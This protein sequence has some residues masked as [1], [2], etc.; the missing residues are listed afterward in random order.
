MNPSTAAVFVEKRGD[1]GQRA[2]LRYIYSGQLPTADALRQVLAG[3]RPD[4]GWQS[5]WA[6]DYSSIDATCY[7]LAQAEQLALGAGEPALMRAL[8]FLAQRQQADGAWE[9]EP[10]LSSM[11]PP[12]AMPGSREARLYLTANSGYWLAR[13]AP[14]EMGSLRESAT[15]AAGYLLLYLGGRDRLPSFLQADW[16]AAGMWQ[17]LGR[18]DLA[19]RLCTFLESRVSEMPA[20]SLAWLILA[21]RGAGLDASHTLLAAAAARLDALQTEDGHWP[22]EDGPGRDVDATLDALFALR[23]VGLL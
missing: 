22:G 20:G 12:W 21:L 6:P 8:H 4:G 5:S 2:R 23:R 13:L 10:D 14:A 11:A 16:L 15:R 1:P 17:C 7:G 18:A 9:E 3:Q 19:N